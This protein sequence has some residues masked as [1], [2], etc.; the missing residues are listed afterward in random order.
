MCLVSVPGETSLCASQEL[1]PFQ[2]GQQFVVGTA[3]FVAH[4]YMVSD[5]GL[6]TLKRRNRIMCIDLGTTSTHN[7]CH[8]RI[9]ANHRNRSELFALKWQYLLLVFKQDDTLCSR[10]PN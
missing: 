6:N 9:G 2:K 10:F 1:F 4:T 8:L 7:L 5:F 3:L